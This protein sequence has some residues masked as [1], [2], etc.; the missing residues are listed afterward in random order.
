VFGWWTPDRLPLSLDRTYELPLEILDHMA[1]DSRRLPTPQDYRPG[2]GGHGGVFFAHE[3]TAI[4]AANAAGVAYGRH[5]SFTLPG[6]AR[7][8]SAR[9]DS[10]ENR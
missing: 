10:R 6:T 7:H 5:L 3:S 1:N 4:E 8:P 9:S 2:N